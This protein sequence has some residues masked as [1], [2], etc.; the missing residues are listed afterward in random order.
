MQI[1]SLE[2]WWNAVDEKWEYL[3]EIV[4]HHFD[5]SAMAYEV[6]C[7]SSSKPTGRTLS[8]ELDWLRGNRDER[9]H[10]YFNKSWCLASD[11][12]AY[13]V[14]YWGLFCDLC[15]ESWVFQTEEET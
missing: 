2:A 15:S 11:A 7:D 6:P 10:S 4:F 13:S 8:E 1:D 14:P 12:Y 3:T 5:Y 9:L